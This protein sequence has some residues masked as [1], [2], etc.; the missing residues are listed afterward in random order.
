MLILRRVICGKW[1]SFSVPWFPC[2]QNGDDNG[3]YF[4]EYWEDS[5]SSIHLTCL[6]QG[7][8]IIDAQDIFIV[9]II[10]IIYYMVVIVLN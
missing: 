8:H 9:L 3:I 10:I 5:M 7:L 6:K 1:F 4:I 2:L